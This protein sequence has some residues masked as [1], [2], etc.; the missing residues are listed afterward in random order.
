MLSIGIL[1]FKSPVTLRNTLLSYQASGLLDFTDDIIVVIQPSEVSTKEYEVCMEFKQIRKIFVNEENTRMAGGIDLI[2]KEAKYDYILFLECD[3]RVCLKK[4]NLY[5]LLTH[6]LELL[7]NGIDI[8]RLRSLKQPG[9]PIQHNLYKSSFDK[10][11]AECMS[12]LYLVTHFLEN[13]EIVF[14][15]YIKR[16]NTRNL[17]YLMSSKHACYTNNPHIVSKTFYNKYI[18]PHVIYGATLESQIGFVWSKFDHKIC[19]TEGC[20]THL[21]MDGHKLCSCCAIECGGATNKCGHKCCE[22]NIPS[23]PFQDSDL[24]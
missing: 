9:H 5:S 14:P 18:K 8:V 20:F 12:Q 23:N 2:Q 10:N 17:T 1:T 19:L 22:G 15:D 4:E 16:L 6:T 11:N 13:P 3:F 24:I 21:R 7:N